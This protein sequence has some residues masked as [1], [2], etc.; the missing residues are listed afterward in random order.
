MKRF[1]LQV[2]VITI[3][4]GT[5]GAL[6]TGAWLKDDF[7]AGRAFS[8]NDIPYSVIITDRNGEEIHRSFGNQNREWTDLQN[9]PLALRDIFLLAEDKRFYN[10][11]GVD[12]KGL[13]RAMWI[14]L[15]AGGFK[16]GGSTITQQI[17]RKAFLKDK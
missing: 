7:K 17:A 2:L 4:F 9:M 10:H 16:Q 15:K 8:K 6:I 13:S 14:N 5:V 1:I 3:L 12:L 11:Y